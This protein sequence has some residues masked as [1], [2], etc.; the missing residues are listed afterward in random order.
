MKTNFK[1]LFIKHLNMFQCIYI[2][3]H[4]CVH[5]R[6][7]ITCYLN[8]T[9]WLNEININS[10]AGKYLVFRPCLL[11]HPVPWESK[12]CSDTK[13]KCTIK[14][15]FRSGKK[16]KYSSQLTAPPLYTQGHWGHIN[17]L[18]VWC[19]SHVQI[20]T[21]RTI[22]CLKWELFSQEHIQYMPV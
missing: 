3:T 14:M 18:Y 5:L 11:S 9:L 8:E 17:F 22:I 1:I 7:C 12:F 21:G 19:P 6:I 20:S 13:E 15:Q 16:F 4:T 10:C 2:Y